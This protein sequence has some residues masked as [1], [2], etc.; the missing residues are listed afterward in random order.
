M[1]HLVQALVRS[2]CRVCDSL[3]KVSSET[4]TNID[5]LRSEYY[6]KYRV[7][8]R[9]HGNRLLTK[10]QEDVLLHLAVS[11]SACNKG[12]NRRLF[13]TVMKEVFDL[14]PSR[15]WMNDWTKAN[16]KHLSQRKTKHLA[17]KRNSSDMLAEV[18]SFIHQVE[19]QRTRT[20]MTA[21]NVVNY[22]ETRVAI[23]TDGEVVLESKA[24]DRA[25]SHGHHAQVLGSLLAFIAADG[26]VLCTFWI[27]RADY[28]E[29]GVAQVE[30][31]TK[32]T[33]YPLRRSWA[34]YLGFTETGY[35]N[36]VTFETCIKAFCEE[37][38]AH[39]KGD[40]V[41]LFGDQLGSH[42]RVGLARAAL[43]M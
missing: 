30:V 35:L 25:N 19:D 22:D 12:W 40:H 8:E 36:D 16:K 7:Q 42:T 10:R 4:G 39:R 31:F 11:F 37:W 21:S 23:T 38:K 9:H 18:E 5:A 2:G 26:S 33:R 29:E 15:H 14:S 20:T 43:D 41:W 17:K 1:A 6:R 24:K 28:N 27:S 34:R 3:A 32:D 13:R